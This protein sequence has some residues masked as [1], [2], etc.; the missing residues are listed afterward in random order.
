[1]LKDKVNFVVLEGLLTV[2]LEHNEADTTVPGFAEARERLKCYNMSL[3][4][5]HVY[6]KHMNR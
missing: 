4:E 2:L 5:P 6:D 1:V 3:S